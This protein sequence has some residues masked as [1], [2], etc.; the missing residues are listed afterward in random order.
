MISK[1]NVEILKTLNKSFLKVKFSTFQHTNIKRNI[2]VKIFLNLYT[3]FGI[4]P[5][6]FFLIGH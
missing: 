5:L 3:L 6:N 4:L 1:Q 2:F